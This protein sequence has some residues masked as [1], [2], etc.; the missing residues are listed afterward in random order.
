VAASVANV[1]EVTPDG[2]RPLST[3]VQQLRPLG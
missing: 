2:G 3:Y 1:V